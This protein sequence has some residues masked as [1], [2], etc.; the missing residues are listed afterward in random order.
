MKPVGFKYVNKVLSPNG[1][2]YSP[3]VTGVDS[4]PI[5]TDGEQCV[6]CWRM[7]LRE[8]LSALIFGRIWVAVLSG[9]TQP[10]ICVN[11]NRDYLQEEKDA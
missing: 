4:L 2:K 8:R 10:P 1:Q 7:S 9:H 5:W 11:A 6:S 3:N